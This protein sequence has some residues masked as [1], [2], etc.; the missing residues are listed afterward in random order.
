MRKILFALSAIVLTLLAATK[1]YMFS[2][3]EENASITQH[4]WTKY[5]YVDTCTTRYAVV[6]DWNG[7]CGIYDLEKKENITELEY[8]AL[9]FSKMMDLDDGSQAT[10]FYGYKGH[11]EGVVSVAPSGE[12]LDIMM[13]DKTESYTLDSCRTIDQNITALCKELLSN[14]MKENGGHYGQVLVAETQTGN[15]KAWVALE[16][17][18]HDGN[19]TDA[20]LLKHQLCSDPQKLL[21]AIM[22]IVEGNTSLNDNASAKCGVDSIVDMLKKDY[23]WQPEWMSIPDCPREMDALSVVTLYNQ[24]ALDAKSLVIP[25][26]NTD[27]IRIMPTEGF[28]ERDFLV[29]HIMRQC[30]KAILQDGGIGSEWTTKKVDIAGNYIVH[31]N[32]RPTLYDDNL[33]D[34]DQYYSEE[35]LSTYDQLIFVGYFPSDD[36][37]Y[38]IC[39]SMDTERMS[40]DGKV[41]SNTVNRLAEYLDEH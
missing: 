32:C 35:G 38:T 13:L 25:S 27:S 15:I 14:D 33:K 28:P 19:I 22:S 1:A 3:N 16:D 41:I 20:P 12:V 34:L 4:K 6:H 7:R 29:T 40:A 26:V 39:V 37:R 2:Q 9:Y 24:I 30:L 36:P 18:C 11:Q 17:E 8:R 10:V 23:S 31:H 5:E 21:W